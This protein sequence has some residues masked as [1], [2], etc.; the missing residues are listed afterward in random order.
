M[1]TTL[2][3]VLATNLDYLGKIWN[4]PNT[5]VGLLYGGVGY[6]LGH[7]MKTSPTITFGHNAIQFLNN[8]LSTTAVT[9]GNVVVYAGNC[10]HSNGACVYHPQAVRHSDQ[11]LGL[12][13]MQHTLQGQVLG[14]LYFPAH[15]VFGVLAL[16][17]TWR[18]KASLIAR[19]H[20][21]INIL[22]TGPHMCPPRPWW[23]QTK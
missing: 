2:I 23:F 1:K 21:P 17:C 7:I 18:S 4:G 3:T 13:E 19:W 16:L 5:A 10:Y 11:V 8:P 22:E 9:L 6:A 12:E 14:P 15:C 20:S